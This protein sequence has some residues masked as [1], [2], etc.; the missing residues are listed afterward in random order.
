MMS[1]PEQVLPFELYVIFDVNYVTYT[2]S[3]QCSILHH[4]FLHACVNVLP[5][6]LASKLIND[7]SAALSEDL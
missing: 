3:H 1:H 7:A 2:T 5:T 6:S 4:I